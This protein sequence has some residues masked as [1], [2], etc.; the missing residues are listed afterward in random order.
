MRA[1]PP[2]GL[3]SMRDMPERRRREG[4]LYALASSTCTSTP[5]RAEGEET[6]SAWARIY[7]AVLAEQGFVLVYRHP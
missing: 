1:R 3:V 6:S 4:E 2:H 5:G 7:R